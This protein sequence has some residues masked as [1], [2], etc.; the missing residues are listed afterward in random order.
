MKKLILLIVLA[1]AAALGSAPQATAQVSIQINI[2]KQPAWGPAG[3]DYARWYYFPALNIYYDVD[4]GLFYVLSGNRWRSY[5]TLPRRYRTYDLYTTYKVVI[6]DDQPWRYNTRHV[7]D[8]A[9]FR[10]DRSQTPI[11]DSRDPRYEQ[12]RNSPP[13]VSSG[14]NRNSNNNSRRT[15]T[16]TNT[17]SRN[18][19]NTTNQ[20]GNSRGN[21]NN[22]NNSNSRRSR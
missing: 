20:S 7:R 21:S 9:Q 3:F 5:R 1:V 11:R 8:Y 14:N 19:N 22:S 2:G 13:N 12:H 16:T 4:A 17:R 10:N 15:T 18:D 6:H